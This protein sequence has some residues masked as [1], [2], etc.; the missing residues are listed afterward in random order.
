MKIE[1]N[2]QDVGI[3]FV[4][5]YVNIKGHE[6]RLIKKTL[7]LEQEVVDCDVEDVKKIIKDKFQGVCEILYVDIFEESALKMI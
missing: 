3:Y 5:F 1:D 6:R 7:V 2:W 4:G